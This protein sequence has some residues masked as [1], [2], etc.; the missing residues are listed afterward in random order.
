MCYLLF[1]P[2]AKKCLSRI[3]FEV[4]VSRNVNCSPESQVVQ[5]DHGL[6]TQTPAP[7]LPSQVLYDGGRPLVFLALMWLSSDL[8]MSLALEEIAC[9]SLTDN[10]LS[11]KRARE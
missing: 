9:S 3:D 4:V 8:W 7:A 1:G 2:V 5:I 11:E 10:Y 6:S